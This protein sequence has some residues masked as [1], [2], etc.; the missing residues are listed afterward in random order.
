MGTREAS[1]VTG[2]A[3][4]QRVR[5]A[6]HDLR[7]ILRMKTEAAMPAEISEPIVCHLM[8]WGWAEGHSPHDA[9]FGTERVQI[10]YSKV[11]YVGCKRESLADWEYLAWVHAPARLPRLLLLIPSGVLRSAVFSKDTFHILTN[12]ET[13]RRARGLRAWE[14]G[15]ETVDD[16][17]RRVKGSR[18]KSLPAR[19]ALAQL[20]AD[21]FEHRRRRKD[22]RASSSPTPKSSSLSDRTAS[23]RAHTSRQREAEVGR[24]DLSAVNG[25]KYRAT[26][27]G[28]TLEAKVVNGALI[29]SGVKGLRFRSLSGA[30]EHFTGY[31]VNGNVFWRPA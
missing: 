4:E 5:H 8:G 15:V 14:F 27:R 17:E 25:K 21:L 19:Q 30:A 11:G 10:K 26:F 13:L 31:A 3:L 28:R 18:L 2:L 20:E 23:S 29:V 1:V 7:L 6:V 16:L 24:G 12:I 22:E 9:M